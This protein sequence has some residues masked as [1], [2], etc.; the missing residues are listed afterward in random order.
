M[1]EATAAVV[2][3]F[4]PWELKTMWTGTALNRAE[5]RLN[6]EQPETYQAIL[7]DA[8]DYGVAIEYDARGSDVGQYGHATNY[9]LLPAVD[10]E[11]IEHENTDLDPEIA[12]MLAE[13]WADEIIDVVT[14]AQESTPLSAKQF[15]TLITSN[16]PNC[17]EKEAADAMGISVGNYRGKVGDVKDKQ[18]RC[19]EGEILDRL[20]KQHSSGFKAVDREIGDWETHS[21]LVKPSDLLEARIDGL[22]SDWKQIRESREDRTHDTYEQS[23][24]RTAHIEGVDNLFV[25]STAKADHDD[26][27]RLDIDGVGHPGADLHREGENIQTSVWLDTAKTIKLYRELGKMLEQ[28]GIFDQETITDSDGLAEWVTEHAEPGT[29]VR[30]EDHDASL[31]DATPQ[32]NF[33][34]E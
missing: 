9:Q 5:N 10:E 25:A 31:L 22:E 8:T 18:E 21:D 15:A 20:S 6:A 23:H 24:W 3:D 13:T 19:E 34:G 14:E 26:F 11:I 33:K 1:D 4:C 29:R 12:R 7:N 17:S 2:I 32:A 16:D 28:T 30:I 27:A